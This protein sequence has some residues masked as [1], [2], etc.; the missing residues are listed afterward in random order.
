MATLTGNFVCDSSTTANFKSW[1]Q[2]ISTAFSTFGWL[3][4]SDTGQVNWSTISSPPG[5][6]AYV[7]EIWQPNDGVS[8][9]FYVKMEYGN[10]SGSS[11]S[12]SIRITV[13]VSTN[14]AGTITGTYIMGPLYT[15][16][17]NA[18]SVNSS[19]TYAC[20]Y[21]GAAGR[22]SVLLWPSQGGNDPQA[23]A[24]ERSLNSSGTYTGAYVT[25]VASGAQSQSTDW[26]HHS[27]Q[28][29]VFGVGLGPTSSRG[30]GSSNSLPCLAVRLMNPNNASTFF[31][32]G[33]PF[34]AVAPSIGYYDCPMT[35]IGIGQ[36]VDIAEQVAF[37]VTLYGSSRVYMPTKAS[38]I[39]LIFNAARDTAYCIR[40]D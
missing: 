37:S 40:Y 17:Q 10:W 18:I 34:D 31:N 22:I 23:F 14:G 38:D 29:L 19:T 7:Y 25:V 16:F 30:S 27:Q 9:N 39:C 5:S 8:P 36:P 26:P 33:I 20:Y 21:S 13:G 11:N 12:P 35:S 6:G 24:I 2:S 4:S 1:A 32:G 28:S 3:Q 15:A